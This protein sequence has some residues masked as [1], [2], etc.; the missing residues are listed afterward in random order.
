MRTST[1]SHVSH[2]VVTAYGNTARNVIHAYRSGGERVVG[3]AEK[4]WESALQASST[5]LTAEVQANAR[6][7][8]KVVG[9]YYVKGLELT[10]NAADALVSQIVKMAEMGVSQMAANA[11]LFEEKTGTSALSKLSDAAL[12]AAHAVNKIAAQIEQKSSQ[13]ASKIA[14]TEDLSTMARRASPFRKARAR[15]AL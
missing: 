10:T 8:Q 14:G 11:S 9:S 3:Y 12:P 6:H 4:R 2:E 13:L 7:A 15:K 5:Q 1:L